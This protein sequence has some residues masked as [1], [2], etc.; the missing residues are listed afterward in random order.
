MRKALVLGATGEVGNHILQ[1]LLKSYSYQT[2]IALGRDSIFDLDDHPKLI[3]QTIDFE[4][5]QVDVEMVR[6]AD[7][8]CAIGTGNPALFEQI[9]YAYV[10]NVA[11]RLEGLVASFNLVSAMGANSRNRFYPYLQVKGRLERDLLQ[12]DLGT[13]R[14]FRPSML[15]APNRKNLDWSEALWIRIFQGIS[16]YLNGNMTGWKGIEPDQVAAAM[17]GATLRESEDLIYLWEEMMN[18][19]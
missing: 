8:F 5:P 6:G 15:L 1:R 2:V 10:M 4:N 3:R 9:D 14:F 16:P 13:I 18:L 19:Q 7:V 11:Q 17:V 12:L